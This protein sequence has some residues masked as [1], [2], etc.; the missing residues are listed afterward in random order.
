MKDIRAELVRIDQNGHAHPVGLVASQRLR[1]RAGAYRMLPAPG[2]VVLLRY[3]GEDGRRDD[4]DGAIVRLAGEIT[5]PGTVA[6]I[7]AMVAQSGWRGELVVLDGE[8]TRSIFFERGL[9]M[10]A[11]TTVVAE[12]LGNVLCRYGAITRAEH[13][14][15]LERLAWGQ[16]LGEAAVEIGLLSSEQ[17]YEYIRRQVEDVVYATLTVSDGTF[18]FLDGFD[19]GRLAARYAVSALSLLMEG[20]TRLDE[21]RYFRQKIPS[22]DYVPCQVEGAG[23]PP[24]EWAELYAAVDGRRTIDE[25]GRLTGKR[26]FETTKAVYQLAQSKYLTVRAPRL[27]GGT[28]A[29]VD[30]ANSAME[31]IFRA[32]KGNAKS[33]AV[34]SG[35]AKFVRS[36]PNASLFEGAGPDEQ[37]QL[38]P[39]TL[40]TNLSR[41]QISADREHFLRQMLHEYVSFA[42]FSA[43]AVLGPER[44]SSLSREVGAVLSRLHLGG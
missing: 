1:A 25:L 37:G 28:Q 31:G 32:L 39:E 8:N 5:A 34:Q 22:A 41:A 35:L 15:L 38:D 23:E 29:I 12:R 3:T 7:V 6:D 9:V 20:V 40:A 11:H 16:R 44:Q 4:Q 14:M 24:A 10:G 27:M 30:T 21:M 26:E 33:S 17:V 43:G 36:G 18:F 42:L 19:E 13:E 2:H